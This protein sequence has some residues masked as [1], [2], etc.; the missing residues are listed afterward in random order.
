[1]SATRWISLM[2]QWPRAA[3]ESLT[4]NDWLWMHLAIDHGA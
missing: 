3:K 2:W 1:M 4:E